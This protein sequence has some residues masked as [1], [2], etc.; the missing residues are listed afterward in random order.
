[1]SMGKKMSI[2]H[3]QKLCVLS[4]TLSHYIEVNMYIQSR[5]KLASSPELTPFLTCE[6][7]M[8][9]IK[10]ENIKQLTFML[11]IWIISFTGVTAAFVL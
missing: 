8:C 6:P 3:G 5:R 2:T 9:K 10:R 1:M 7:I 4:L 11:E